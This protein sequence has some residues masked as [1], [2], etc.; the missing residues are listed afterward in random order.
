M[1]DV[2]IVDSVRSAVGK[3]NGSLANVRPDDLAATIIR[4][5][6]QRNP[7]FDPAVLDEVILGAANQAELTLIAVRHGLIET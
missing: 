4:S 7:G 6:L 5:L 3:F 1:Q 2:F